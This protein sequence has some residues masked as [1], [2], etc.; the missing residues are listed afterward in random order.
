M[1]D[2]RLAGARVGLGKVARWSAVPSGPKVG[3]DLLIWASTASSS[4]TREK[5]F[6]AVQRAGTFR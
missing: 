6:I 1:A 3:H 2:G 4:A 5:P